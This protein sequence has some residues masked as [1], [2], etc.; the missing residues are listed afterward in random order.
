[1]SNLCWTPEEEKIIAEIMATETMH[2]PASIHGI[3]R[4]RCSRPEALRRLQ[5]RKKNGVYHPPTLQW[6]KDWVYEPVTPDRPVPAYAF[7]ADV[8]GEV[9]EAIEVAS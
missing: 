1:M 5:R 9:I 8:V 4:I 2:D 3:A 7:G 6:V